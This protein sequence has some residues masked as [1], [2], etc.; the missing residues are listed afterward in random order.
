MVSVS[1]PTVVTSAQSEAFVSL[2]LDSAQT[3]DT[4]SE[5]DTYER[6]RGRRPRGRESSRRPG[7]DRAAGAG[8][9]S[10]DDGQAAADI[11][12]KISTLANTL[13]VHPKL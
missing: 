1:T 5:S 3:M 10:R 4:S 13:Q 6:M 11:S 9:S 12:D 8:G 2:L 7:R